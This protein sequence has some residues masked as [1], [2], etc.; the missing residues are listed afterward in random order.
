MR[1]DDKDHKIIN[2]LKKNSREPIREIAKKTKL[3]PSTV[4]VRIRKLVAEGVIDKFTLK[5]NNELMDEGFIAIILLNTDNL[6]PKVIS[7]KQ[8][9]EIFGITGEYDILMKAKFKGVS[10]FNDFVLALRKL[11]NIKQT[12]SMV[13]TANIKEDI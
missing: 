3:R 2:V 7:N 5:L 13:V 11:Y 10:E 9:K 1:L 6:D 12:L 8:V 4:H